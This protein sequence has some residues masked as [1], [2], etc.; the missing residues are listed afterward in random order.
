MDWRA[1]RVSGPERPAG[2]GAAGRPAGGRGC[3]RHREGMDRRP[4]FRALAEHGLDSFVVNLGGNVMAPGRSRT[5]AHGAWDC[6]IHA[7]RAPSWA[8]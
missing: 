5:A 2:P 3:G 7:T 6:R 1:L 4:A 8:L